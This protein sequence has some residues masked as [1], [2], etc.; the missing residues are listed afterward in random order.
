MKE[1]RADTVVKGAD[2]ALSAAILLGRVWA[3][4]AQ[5][6]AVRREEVTNSRVVKL[7]TV[8][9]LKCEDGTTEL[10]GDIGVKTR[11]SGE[12]VGLATK[13]KSPHI[14]RKIIQNHQIV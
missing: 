7:F 14:M 3:G 8:I 13:R 2:D 12:D 6:G 1:Q 4:E 11:K 10:S 9:S 5:D